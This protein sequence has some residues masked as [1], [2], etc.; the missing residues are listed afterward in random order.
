MNFPIIDYTKYKTLTVDVFDTLLLRKIWPED[1]QF[2]KVAGLW[3]KI[4][5]EE[6]GLDFDPL[7]LYFYRIY[8]RGMLH[9]GKKIENDEK[10]DTGVDYVIL[11][12]VEWFGAIVDMVADQNN[13]II[14]NE[15]RQNILAR[16][17]AIEILVEKE[18]LIV[19]KNL[20]DWIRK[21]KKLGLKIYFLSDMYLRNTDIFNLLSHFGI[22]NLFDGGFTSSDVKRGKWSGNLY[23]YLNEGHIKF[24]SNFHLGDNNESDHLMP[25]SLGIKSFQYSIT[26]NGFYKRIILAYG[27]L[28]L[29]LIIYRHRKKIANTF[30]KKFRIIVSKD[31]HST[32]YY[33]GSLFAAPLIA[34]LF[35]VIF[36][37]GFTRKK[38]IAISS[39]ANIFKIYVEKLITNMSWKESVLYFPQ[40]NRE[41]VLLALINAIYL[42]LD[43]KRNDCLELLSLVKKERGMLTRDDFFEFIFD[44]KLID[45]PESAFGLSEDEF[46]SLVGRLIIDGKAKRVGD[47]TLSINN[48]LNQIGECEI[49]L[50]DVGWN[51]S[52]QALLQKYLQ[53]MDKN[54][55]VN[56]LYLGFREG[57]GRRSL[58][59]GFSLGCL[60]PDIGSRPGS[61][62]FVPDIWEFIYTNKT[63]GTD[64]NI[65]IQSGLNDA[66]IDFKKQI[67]IP[68]ME[69][70]LSLRKDLHSLLYSP[71]KKEINVLGSI[72]PESGFKLEQ[73]IRLVNR[74]LTKME[75]IFGLMFD[76]SRTIKMLD[77]PYCWRAG[78]IRFYKVELLYKIIA[79]IRRALSLN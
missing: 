7:D 57:S 11:G 5:Q 27:S 31:I 58:I 36:F 13:I 38:I 9:V 21:I 53:I 40:I 32:A 1:L 45:M 2:L 54:N 67:K 44:K 33:I 39:E 3:V 60:I 28:K 14:T 65:S 25:K 73:N 76:Q 47:A 42:N 17:I 43:K 61:D 18:N 68:P 41:V 4:I 66:V 63:Y 12:I 62:F 48:L 79:G 75:V 30:S 55:I 71:N 52:V 51:G 20:V 72:I 64:F 23:K 34:F 56:G 49:N 74:D 6:L 16:L 50:V 8:A 78:F 19:N 35:E 15:S 59:K 26:R 77:K 69:F 46:N 29:K 10:Q 37:A 22:E 70:F 24:D